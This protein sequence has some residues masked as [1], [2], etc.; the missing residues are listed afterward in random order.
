M[1]GLMRGDAEATSL[2][3]WSSLAGR[4]RL[5]TNSGTILAEFANRSGVTA[6]RRLGAVRDEAT[7]GAQE[8]V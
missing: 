7:L 8:T 2:S 5:V 1:H 6:L 3:T 4:F